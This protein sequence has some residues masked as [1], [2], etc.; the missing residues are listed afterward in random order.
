[1][2]S[3]GPRRHGYE[4]RSRQTHSVTKAADAHSEYE[5]LPDFLWQQWLREHSSI[6]LLLPVLLYFI[7]LAS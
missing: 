7:R 5:I 6:L 1:M 4:R 3:A 2:A